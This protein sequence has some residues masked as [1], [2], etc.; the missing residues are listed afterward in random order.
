MSNKSAQPQLSLEE[1]T[2]TPV[3]GNRLVSFFRTNF[4]AGIL[5]IAPIALTF[6]ILRAL[7]IT[8][9]QTLISL[10]PPHLRPENYLPVEIP[11]L[12]LVAGFII[13]VFI[14]LFVRNFIGRKLL[15]WGESFLHAIPGVSTI[16]GAIKQITETLTSTNST[17]FREVVLVEYPRKG[18]WGIGFVT[19]TTGT[20]VNE[21][22]PEDMLNVFVPT[23]PNPTSGFL[24]FYPKEDVIP[25]NMTIEQGIKMVVSAGI[26]TP[27]PAEAKKAV[28]EEAKAEA[29]APVSKK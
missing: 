14:G 10:L 21:K 4:F 2:P 22:T 25:L 1:N 29:S 18:S 6:Y 8:L 13:L 23:T 28:K 20:I 11:G 24:L 15:N 12:G 27:T 7:V 26:I 5:A 9:D 3:K 16:Y 17:S 19:G